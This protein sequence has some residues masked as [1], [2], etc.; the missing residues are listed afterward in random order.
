[1]REEFNTKF[2]HVNG[3]EMMYAASFDI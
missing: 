2:A 1:M 3:K